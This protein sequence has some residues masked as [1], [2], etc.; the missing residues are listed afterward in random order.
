MVSTSDK[1]EEVLPSPEQYPHLNHAVRYVALFRSGLVRQADQEKM[2]D[3]MSAALRKVGVTR[4]LSSTAVCADVLMF[5]A[6]F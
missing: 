4:N 6:Q 1:N 5:R 2:D 3:A